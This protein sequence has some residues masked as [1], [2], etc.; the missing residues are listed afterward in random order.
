MVTTEEVWTSLRGE[1][2]GFL[3]K[4]VRDEHLA[5]DLL[6]ETFV[7]VHDGLAQV[8]REDRVG[9]W[10]RSIARNVVTDHRRAARAPE[11]LDADDVADRSHAEPN[12]NALVEGWLLDSIALL[13]PE[14]RRALELAEVQGLPQA[15][16]A[17]LC[18]LSLSGAKSRV[19][20]GRKLLRETVLAC[21]HLE[22]DRRGN[23]LGHTPRRGSCGCDG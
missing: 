6:Q 1:L 13:P 17:E 5:E 16:V 4:R 21:C 7:R 23:V 11:P 3:R 10:V 22:L 12:E 15:R 14:Y 2:L 20:R 18:G 9:A 19:Q 8:E